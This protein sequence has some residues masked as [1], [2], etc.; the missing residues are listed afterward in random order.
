MPDEYL[1]RLSAEDKADKLKKNL[2]QFVEYKYFAAWLDDKII[3]ILILGPCRDIDLNSA[4]IGE[5][6]AIYL[7]PDHFGM[8]YGY[9]IMEFA[10]SKLKINFN[11]VILWVLEENL[12]A[13]A[14]YE[15]VGFNFDG[16]KKEI[17]LGKTL[18]E[19]RYCLN[20]MEVKMKQTYF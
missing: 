3:G 16:T 7:H 4:D 10:I 18:L 2:T 11:K 9:K 13:R 17:V 6:C 12:Q 14:F 19:M 1:D 5:V 20:F 8:G 15:K